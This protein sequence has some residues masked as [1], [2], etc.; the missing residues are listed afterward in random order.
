M[1]INQGNGERV[2]KKR[3]EKKKGKKKKKHEDENR[4]KSGGASSRP[5][6]GERKEEGERAL[7]SVGEQVEEFLC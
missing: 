3:E 2:V 6:K 7:A 1:F 5:T 4:T